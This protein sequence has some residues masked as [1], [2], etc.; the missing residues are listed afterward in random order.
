MV[1]G[2]CIIFKAKCIK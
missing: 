2:S 1:V